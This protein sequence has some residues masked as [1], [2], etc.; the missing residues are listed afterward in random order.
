MEGSF[1]QRH[2]TLTVDTLSPLVSFGLMG[3]EGERGGGRGHGEKGIFGGYRAVVVASILLKYSVNC[4]KRRKLLRLP[5]A[6]FLLC[7]TNAISCPL[8]VYLSH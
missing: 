4:R 7:D 8:L 5:G 1:L 6:P 2:C 3:S